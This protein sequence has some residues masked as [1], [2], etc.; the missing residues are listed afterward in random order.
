MQ[1]EG[2]SDIRDPKIVEVLQDKNSELI[3]EKGISVLKIGDAKI[4]I[5]PNLTLPSIAS[6]LFDESKKLRIN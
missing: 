2:K 6:K 3:K 4:K 5:D 1:A